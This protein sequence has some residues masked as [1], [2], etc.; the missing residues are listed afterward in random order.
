MKSPTSV[1][2]FGAS[3]RMG[4]LILELAAWDQEAFTI[5]GAIETEGHPLIDQS[6]KQWPGLSGVDLKLS[7][8][9]KS[10][11][12]PNSV[13]IDFSTPGGTLANLGG[14]IKSGLPTII[15]TTG[16]SE[17]DETRIRE[18]SSHLPLLFVPNTSRGVN[19]L[20][21]LVRQAATLMGP[22]YDIEIIEMHHHHKQDAPS[23]TARRL[24]QVVLEEKQGDYDINVVHGRSGQVGARSPNE[25]GMHA[26][27][28]GDVAGDH[29][30]ILAGRG[31]RIELTHR[32]SGR[33]TFARG[34]LH[35]ADWLRDKDP[36]LYSMEDVLGLQV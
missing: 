29:T 20:F 15:G 11:V 1:I 9:M 34:A 30:L 16:F 8:T 21:W 22:E 7:A 13:I 36:G 17:K 18:A 3:G 28:G 35:A 14:Y 33:E 31:E 5:D 24:A 26:L 25:I 4:R 6:I 2:I 19:V 27:R 32:A 12:K 10:Q 23:G